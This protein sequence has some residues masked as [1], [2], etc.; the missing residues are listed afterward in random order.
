[1]FVIKYS[2]FKIAYIII[3]YVYINPKNFKNK[4]VKKNHENFQKS[5][6]FKIN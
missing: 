1:M 6:Y 2:L 3:F 4:K 5:S